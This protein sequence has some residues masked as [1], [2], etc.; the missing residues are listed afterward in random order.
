MRATWYVL[1]DGTAVD[2]ADC[3]HDEKGHGFTHKS[4]ARVAMSSHNAPK[5]R[6]VE[7]DET[8]ASGKGK[9]METEPNKKPGY[10]NRETKTR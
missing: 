8:A 5:S 1:E 3:T 7:I 4:G 9:E 10:K 6:G 2:P